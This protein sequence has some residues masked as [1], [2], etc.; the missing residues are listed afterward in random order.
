MKVCLYQ[1]DLHI[2]LIE[3]NCL[4]NQ[5]TCSNKNCIPS[6][7]ICNGFDD[8]GDNSDEIE[9]CYRMNILQVYQY[10][11]SNYKIQL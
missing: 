1:N 6:V 3:G 10:F 7:K 2:G 4:N 5:Y 9:A 11:P 8:C